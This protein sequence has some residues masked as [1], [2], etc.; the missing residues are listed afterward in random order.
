MQDRPFQCPCCDYYSLEARGSFEICPICYWE[1][2][3][4]DLDELEKVSG[5]NHMSLRQGRENF[6]Q[7]GACDHAAVALV[8]S[9]SER[10]GVRRELRATYH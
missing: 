8:L 1:D 7:I 5:P 2:D 4:Q 10:M 6:E 3:G 9:P